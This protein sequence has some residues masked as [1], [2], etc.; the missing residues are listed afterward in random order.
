MSNPN[1]DLGEWLLRDVLK[2]KDGQLVTMD[3]LD[4]K[5]VNAVIFTKHK[6]G[7]YSVDFSYVDE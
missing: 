6:N 4:D 1:K 3:I 5:G 7:T 2:L